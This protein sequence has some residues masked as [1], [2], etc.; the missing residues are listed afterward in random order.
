MAY[1]VTDSGELI[2]RDNSESD[3]MTDPRTYAYLIRTENNADLTADEKGEIE[4]NFEKRCDCTRDCCGH[5]NGGITSITRV[6]PG[7][8]IAIATFIRNY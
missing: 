6:W 1:T 5:Y 4:D 8:Y 2:P 3:D 7:K